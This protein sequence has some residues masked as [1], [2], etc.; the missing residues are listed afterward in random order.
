MPKRLGIMGGTFDP[1]HLG[2]LRTAEEACETLKLDSILFV[3]ASEPPH[4]PG[5]VV[6]SFEHRR[7]ML[8]LAIAGNSRFV[9]SDVERKLP[10]KSY[11]VNTLRKLHEEFPGAELFFLVGMDAFLDMDCWFQYREL[12]RLAGIVVLKRPGYDE[13]DIG[14][15][16]RRKVSDRFARGAGSES[17]T[18]PDLFP[19]HCLR[20]AAMD[21]S[22][23]HIRQLAALGRSIRYLVPQDVVSYICE[24][25]L[26]RQCGRD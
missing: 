22:S 26:Y 7:R 9:L 16:L 1:V 8:E 13:D 23:T 18:H 21:I 17:F 11:T 24:E 14:E 4:K 2:H 12:F 15:F 5:E 25:K 20:N 6:L 3:P 10:G 19:V